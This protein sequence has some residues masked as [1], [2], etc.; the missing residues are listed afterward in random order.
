[1]P[2]QAYIKVLLAPAWDHNFPDGPASWLDNVQTGSAA[3]GG[4]VPHWHDK[5]GRRYGTG[6]KYFRLAGRPDNSAQ[7]SEDMQNV[8]Q[9]WPLKTNM[10]ISSSVFTYDADPRVFDSTGNMQATTVAATAGND[11]FGSVANETLYTKNRFRQT[12]LPISSFN[13]NETVQIDIQLQA[14]GSSGSTRTAFP[15]YANHWQ[16]AVHDA[17]IQGSFD[18]GTPLEVDATKLLYPNKPGSTTAATANGNTGSLTYGASQSGRGHQAGIV[19]AGG[20]TG[21]AA[22]VHT[23][24]YEY[25]LNVDSLT[26]SWDTVTSVLPLPH[27][28]AM[29]INTVLD[30]AQLS[31]LAID[32]G[33]MR[34][35]ISVQGVIDDSGNTG[36]Q[37][38]TERWIRKQELQDI[39][40][41]Q[42]GATV[43]FT[44]HDQPFVNPNRYVALTIGPM[45]TENPNGD[46]GRTFSVKPLTKTDT[47]TNKG[48][49]AYYNNGT[50]ADNPLERFSYQLKSL[51]MWR[52]GD[53]PHD[54]M[55][56]TGH[57]IQ[58]AG[59]PEVLEAWDWKPN[60][61]GR[62]RYRGLIKNLEV[63]L[64]GGSP[65]IW[66]FS[67]EFQVFKN[68]TT[69][70]RTTPIEEGTPIRNVD[71]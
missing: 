40:R 65:D 15:P 13:A 50:D 49:S 20:T 33:S 9:W 60:Y 21:T 58:D 44:K 35:T 19:W 3:Y 62:R 16:D 31:G 52:F 55:R 46:Q 61:Q 56:G 37:P 43:P 71:P 4:T 45:Y 8:E 41:G 22:N 66:E 68:E 10:G 39:I 69:F 11:G 6:D 30:P 2:A 29:D 63:T 36:S 32:L 5:T 1:M 27:P 34:E 17:I 51:D 54:D 70:R 47:V 12:G 59:A 14:L 48:Y 57:L 24:G 23:Y 67:F 64:Q 38:P 26:H 7:S 53:E 42:W 25:T 18:T 28:G